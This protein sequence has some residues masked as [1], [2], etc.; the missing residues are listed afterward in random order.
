[1]E[2]SWSIVQRRSVCLS[3][4]ST[5]VLQNFN[6]TSKWVKGGKALRP[7]GKTLYVTTATLRS[8]KGPVARAVEAGIPIHTGSTSRAWH[9][10]V[11]SLFSILPASILLTACYVPL[12]REASKCNSGR[13]LSF[14]FEFVTWLRLASSK[15]ARTV[16][17]RR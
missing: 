2:M 15:I 9:L 7:A 13:C 5:V 4:F 10:V 14:L 16:L 1:M 11:F 6:H 8:H 17:L 12:T 3:I